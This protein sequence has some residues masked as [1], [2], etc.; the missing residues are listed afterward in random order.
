MDLSD[1]FR[2]P[3]WRRFRIEATAPHSLHVTHGDTGKIAVLILRHSRSDW[4]ISAAALA[5]MVEALRDQRIAAGHIVL[6]DKWD[7]I[8]HDSVSAVAGRL[9][10]IEPNPGPWG[11]YFWLDNELKPVANFRSVGSDDE[12]F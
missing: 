8:A 12:P 4:A 6:A 10:G 1:L 2:S 7:V 9:D 11:E 3:R 5:Y